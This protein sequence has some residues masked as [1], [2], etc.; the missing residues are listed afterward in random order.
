MWICGQR[1][2]DQNLYSYYLGYIWHFLLQ[3]LFT[4]IISFDHGHKH[5]KPTE[6]IFGSLAFFFPSELGESWT[7]TK[8]NSQVPPSSSLFVVPFTD[9]RT[10][11]LRAARL[12][13]VSTWVSVQPSS[14][15]SGVFVLCMMLSPSV[16]SSYM[17]DETKHSFLASSAA[18][19]ALRLTCCAL[20]DSALATPMRTCHQYPLS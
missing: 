14:S 5:M 13:K 4:G 8:W 16:D 9:A 6:W 19:F 12:G 20:E 17:H 10:E 11:F 18:F 1:G 7:N 3:K 2:R 15:D